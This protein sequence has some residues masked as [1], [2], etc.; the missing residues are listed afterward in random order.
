MVF[1]DFCSQVDVI[2]LKKNVP[3]SSYPKNMVYHLMLHLKETVGMDLRI[4]MMNRFF[5][6]KNYHQHDGR[7]GNL[8]TSVLRVAFCWPWALE[9][10]Y[11]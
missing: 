3:I 4:I 8:M 11:C 9:F 1:Q 6:S 7:K 2:Q 5:K 10:P